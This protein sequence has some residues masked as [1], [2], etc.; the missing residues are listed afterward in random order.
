[1]I[2]LQYDIILFYIFLVMLVV[3]RPRVLIM[4]V[5]LFYRLNF[6]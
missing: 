4:L 2:L 3:V 5:D 1:M 6:Y